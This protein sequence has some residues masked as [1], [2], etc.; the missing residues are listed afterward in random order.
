MTNRTKSEIP[1]VLYPHVN[2]SSRVEGI[3]MIEELLKKYI[4]VSP[5]D[6]PVC[7]LSKG[8]YI[9]LG[10]HEKDDIGIIVDFIETIPGVGNIGIW[11]RFMGTAKA[12]YYIYIKIQE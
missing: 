9:S 12:L 8:D 2:G 3:N 1:L 10:F 11:G 5:F 4:N 7:G 6:F